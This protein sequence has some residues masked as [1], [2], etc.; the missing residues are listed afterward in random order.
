[1]TRTGQDH[2]TRLGAGRAPSEVSEGAVHAVLASWGLPAR[3]CLTSH[4]THVPRPI[5]GCHQECGSAT[6]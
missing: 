6:G 1:M 2:A 3:Q 5:P 4:P